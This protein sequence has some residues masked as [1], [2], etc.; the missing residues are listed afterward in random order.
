MHP[1]KMISTQELMEDNVVATL[2]NLYPAP[3]NPQVLVNVIWL[4]PD[5]GPLYYKIIRNCNNIL[6]P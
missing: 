5:I 4:H 2:T 3:A 6:F 1:Y